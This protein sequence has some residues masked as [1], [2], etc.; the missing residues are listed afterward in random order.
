M[1]QKVRD[2]ESTEY[3]KKPTGLQKKKV[4]A[5]TGRKTLLATCLC[6]TW[7]SRDTSVT[8]FLEPPVSQGVLGVRSTAR[9]GF[10]WHFLF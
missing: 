3:R 7:P 9:K 6:P 5:H 2:G 10:E 4:P 1:T 8:R